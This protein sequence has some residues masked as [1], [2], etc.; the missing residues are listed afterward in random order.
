MVW[1]FR[2]LL[3]PDDTSDHTVTWAEIAIDFQ[4][5]THCFVQR[6]HDQPLTLEQQACLFRA[7]AKKVSQICFAQVCLT[8]TPK[9]KCQRSPAKS[10]FRLHRCTKSYLQQLCTL[11]PT[12]QK[13]NVY[14]FIP[15]F[16]SSPKASWA[17]PGRRRI[18][19]KQTPIEDVAL[20]S[21][22]RDATSHKTTT[23]SIQWSSSEQTKLDAPRDWRHRQ[24]L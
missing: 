9:S 22:K 6:H 4:A 10:C 24:R 3:W 20:R 11:M 14:S 2:Q 7:A 23:Q 1:Y 19:G 13:I 5:S 15:D 18:R 16:S 12:N 21:K 8:W 17:G